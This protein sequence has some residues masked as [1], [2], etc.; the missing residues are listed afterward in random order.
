MGQPG[1]GR[2]SD[3]FVE[4]NMVYCMGGPGIVLSKTTLNMLSPRLGEC[5]KV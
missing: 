2:D 1:F 4:D 3:D 5:L